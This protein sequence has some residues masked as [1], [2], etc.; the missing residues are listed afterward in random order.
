MAKNK[1]AATCD[2]CRQP[3]AEVR[4]CRRCGADI[5]QACGEDGRHTRSD[6]EGAQDAAWE[7]CTGFR[8]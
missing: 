6:C 5:C 8:L 3:V 7:R 4:P 1:A 2:Q